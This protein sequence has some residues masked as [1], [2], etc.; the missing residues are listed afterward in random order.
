[1]AVRPDGKLL[2]GDNRTALLPSGRVG[3]HHLVQGD[4]VGAPAFSP[5]GTTLYAGSAHVL[6]QRYVIAPDRAVTEVCAR[7]GTGLTRTEWH[8]YVLDAPYR[9]VCGS[10]ASHG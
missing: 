3:E 6:R 10:A 4:L 7:T 5:D 1:M 9:Q 8:T 2:A